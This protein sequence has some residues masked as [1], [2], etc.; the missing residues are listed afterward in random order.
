[1]KLRCAILDDYQNVALSFA[2][3]SE[4]EDRVEPVVYREHTEDERELAEKLQDFPIIVIMRERTPFPASLFARL[5]KLRLLVTTGMRNASIDLAAAAAHGVV[6]SGTGGAGAGTAELTWALLLGLA[7][8][9][10]AENE[11][12]RRNGRWQSTIGVDLYGKRLG[13][14]G[15]GRIGSQVAKVGQAFGMEVAAWSQNLTAERAAEVGVRYAAKDELLSESD[16]VSIHLVLSERTR[17]LLGPRELSLLKPSAYLINT[18]RA[19]IVDQEALIDTLRNGRIA[20][21]GLDVYD[22]EP[23]PPSHPYRSLAN[24]LA[25]PHIGYVTEEA[26][27][28][29]FAQ[30]VDNIRSFLDGRPLRTL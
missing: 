13:L 7:R 6:V 18:S 12:L 30:A 19:P 11:A 28:V 20:G 16:F 24:V 5:P 10:T 25:T 3:W 22:I 15:L 1:M 29:F 9:L 23:L 17:G 21:A 26:Y 4:L 14:L 27:R 8:S 2:D